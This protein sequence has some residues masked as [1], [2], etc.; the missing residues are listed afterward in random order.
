[1]RITG[2]I[3]VTTLLYFIG[4]AGSGKSTLTYAFQEWLTL[5]SYDGITLNLDPGAENLPYT[6][7][8]DIREWIVLKDVMKEHN[9]GPNGAQIACADMLSFKISDIRNLMDEY[10]TDYVL[11]D[12]PGQMELFTLRKSSKYVIEKLGAERSVVVFL[13]DPFIA[14]T[15]SGFISQIMLNATAQFRFTLPTI[16]VLSKVDML[17]QTELETILTWSDDPYALVNAAI[18]ESQT[19][20][21]QLSVELFRVLDDI[22]I[23]RKVIPTSIE[24]KEGLADIYTNV[25]QVFMGGEDLEPH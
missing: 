20:H 23:Y 17:E 14:K 25:Q 11:I 21:S 4:T 13:F 8:I 12:T 19:M 16:N 5:N 6:P 22:G 9:L 1:M 15:P 10:K 18:D 7:D 2:G 3:K 24:S